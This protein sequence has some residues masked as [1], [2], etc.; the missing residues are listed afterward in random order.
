MQ[1]ELCRLAHRANKEQHAGHGQQRPL[2]P[3]NQGNRRIL[4]AAGFA[5]NLGVIKRAK[6][7]KHQ[8]NAEQETEVTHPVD[9]KGLHIGKR[10]GRALEPET[11][12]EVGNQ[13][14][15][16]P[17]EEELDE[18]VAHHQHQHR[19][20]KQRDIAEKAL[21]AGIVMHI[22][23][24]VDVHH[25]RHES[26]H[27]HH[28]RGQIVD[29]KADIEVDASRS[30]PGVDRAIERLAAVLQIHQHIGRQKKRQRHTGNGHDMRGAP[31]DRPAKEAGNQRA[32]QRSQSN[33]QVN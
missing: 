5:E 26:H 25:Q 31:A 18:I 11:D 17:T 12:Q 32:Q 2:M 8:T 21:V 28:H 19:K 33:Q 22:A 1:R 9:Q 30:Q 29:Q 20:G 4:K 6:V 7:G 16:F 23:D 14:H 3:R 27:A 24:G 15:R 10:R 13:T